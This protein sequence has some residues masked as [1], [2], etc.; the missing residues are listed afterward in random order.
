MAYT[1]AHL[2][3]GVILGGKVNMV[4]SV[5]RNHEAY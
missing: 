1:A 5:H 2:N 4:L 3:A